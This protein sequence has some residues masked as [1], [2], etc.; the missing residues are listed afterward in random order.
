MRGVEQPG[1]AGLGITCASLG[2]DVCAAACHLFFL[3][4]LYQFCWLL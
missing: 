1:L 2:L 3:V 4:Y